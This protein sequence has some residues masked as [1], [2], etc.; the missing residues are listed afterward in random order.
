MLLSFHNPSY[1]VLCGYTVSYGLGHILLFEYNQSQGQWSLVPGGAE[2]L[3][4]ITHWGLVTPYGD[5]EMGQHW[6]R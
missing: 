3:T 4:F 1:D 5:R 6:F 2:Q